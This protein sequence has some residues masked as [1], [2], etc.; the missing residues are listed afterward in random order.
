[1]RLGYKKRES[2]EALFKARELLERQKARLT[3]ENLLK[4]AIQILHSRNSVLKEEPG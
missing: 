1:M 3:G 2:K 4:A